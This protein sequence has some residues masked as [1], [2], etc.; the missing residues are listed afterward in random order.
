VPRYEIRF[1]SEAS[2]A[3]AAAVPEMRIVSTGSGTLLIG[4]L[5]AHSEL[6]SVLAR[7][8]D[9]GIEIDEYRRLR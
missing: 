1:A 3:L 8:D 2:D 5:R 7:L 6:Q 9:L 4:E